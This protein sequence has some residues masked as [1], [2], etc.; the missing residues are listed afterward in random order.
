MSAAFIKPRENVQF[1]HTCSFYERNLDPTPNNISVRGEKEIGRRTV[2]RSYSVYCKSSLIATV[3]ADN[4]RRFA[5]QN[6]RL[7]ARS[8]TIY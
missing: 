4:L 7:L 2:I 8:A 6:E 5:P 3:F 1:V